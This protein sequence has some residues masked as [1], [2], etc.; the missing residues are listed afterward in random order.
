VEVDSEKV[1]QDN[2]GSILAVDLSRTESVPGNL[3]V[4]SDG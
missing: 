1:E 2:A 3:R 4:D